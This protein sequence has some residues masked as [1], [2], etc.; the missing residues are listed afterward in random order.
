MPK[1][2]RLADPIRLK[3][4]ATDYSRLRLILAVGMQAWGSTVH[5]GRLSAQAGGITGV[6]SQQ[7]SASNVKS[8]RVAGVVRF[9]MISAGSAHTCA[10]GEDGQGF[11]WGD[12]RSGATGDGSGAVLRAPTAVMSS[13]RY[14]EI[15]SGGGFSCGRTVHSDIYCWGKSHAVPSYPK[16]AMTPMRIDLPV[17]AA[18]LAVGLRHA[19]ALSSD[20]AAYCWGWNVDGEL[21]NG[22]SGISAAFVVKPQLVFG[23]ARFLTLAT[24]AN[25][26][27]ALTRD[28][29]P[30]CW[31]SDID[32]VLSG[33]GPESCGPVAPVR[34]SSKPVAID[35]TPP[36]VELAAGQSHACGRT[37]DGAVWCWGSNGSGQLTGQRS[38]TTPHPVR[39]AEFSVDSAAAIAAGGMASC[40]ISTHGDLRCWGED[41]LGS[42]N[43]RFSSVPARLR[44]H[45]HH[46][47]VGAYHSC[48]IARDR[49]S[50][51]WG[52]NQWGA[53]GHGSF[54]RVRRGDRSSS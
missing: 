27:C 31:G 53:L 6:D 20:G 40:A 11:C 25:F 8:C 34:C 38:Q 16:A 30:F 12:G 13:L 1:Y 7:C 22:L 47:T 49:N 54:G 24:G 10:V 5:P 35:G 42:L 46:I 26:T 21:G 29:R 44:M 9:T 45:F 18:G 32:G 50:Y 39:S 17:P 28:G 52:D 15:R 19:C 41:A 51:C 33:R 2:L 23:E 3:G 4:R 14:A 37:V 43:G 48:G 36:L